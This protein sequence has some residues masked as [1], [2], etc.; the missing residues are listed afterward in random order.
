[1]DLQAIRNFVQISDRFA[2][3][4]QPTEN[5]LRGLKDLGFDVVVN[6]GLLDPRYCLPDEAASVAAMGL[7]YHH[8]PVDFQT[9][10]RSDFDRFREL[11][12]ESAFSKV[13]VH[14]ALNWRVACFTAL[15]GELEL[16][17]SRDQ[18][19]AHIRRLWEPNDVWKGF[20]EAVRGTTEM[21][22]PGALSGAERG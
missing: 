6:L 5:Q 8:I 22:K 9:P 18:A 13:F 1:M 7:A 11:M 4:G 16:G 14:C 3:A 19:N 20:L 15:F 2:T 21:S 10:L 12:R 17:W